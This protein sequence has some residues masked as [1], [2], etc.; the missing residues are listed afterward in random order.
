MT[1]RKG[2]SFRTLRTVARLTGPRAVVPYLLVFVLIIPLAWYIVSTRTTR[3][4]HVDLSVRVQI[5]DGVHLLDAEVDPVQ[6]QQV[7]D[8]VED[9]LRARVVFLVRHYGPT[10]DAAGLLGNT[11]IEE[12]TVS[13][14]LSH[15]PFNRDFLVRDSRGFESRYESVVPAVRDLFQVSDVEVAD[16][17]YD[18]D[19]FEQGTGEIRARAVVTPMVVAEPA[20]LAAPLLGDSVSSSQW[21]RVG[22][23]DPEHEGE[24]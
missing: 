19:Y 1:W 15:D 7:L 9:G 3:G 21:V 10:D 18:R 13:R 8:T 6:V 11:L 20:F 12:L 22:T 24:R 23:S 4:E 2:R 17:R 16:D 14:T 5:Q